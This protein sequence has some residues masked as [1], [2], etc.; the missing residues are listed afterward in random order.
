MFGCMSW[1]SRVRDK[2]PL[3]WCNI[4]Q[5]Q[6]VSLKVG[7][8]ERYYSTLKLFMLGNPY[9]DICL[10]FEQMCPIKVSV[11]LK[12]RLKWVYNKNNPDFSILIQS[13]LNKSSNRSYLIRALLRIHRSTDCYYPER[14]LCTA[15]KC[16]IILRLRVRFNVNIQFN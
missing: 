9:P 11:K 8:R 1:K 6:R 15:H 10:F 13:T 4:C 12:N 2:G 5:P 3:N 7:C 16:C 14:W